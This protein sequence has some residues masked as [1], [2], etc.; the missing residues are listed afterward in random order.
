MFGD[1]GGGKA[2]SG[3]LE[4][5]EF[6]SLEI[7]SVAE[8][9]DDSVEVSL[10]GAY[11]VFALKGNAAS[12]FAF[13]LERGLGVLEESEDFVD[14]GALTAEVQ[15]VLAA[16]FSPGEPVVGAE[17]SPAVGAPGGGD[18]ALGGK[19]EWIFAEEG[20]GWVGVLGNG[21]VHGI[22]IQSGGSRGCERGSGV[23]RVR[24]S[25]FG[26]QGSGRSSEKLG[27]GQEGDSLATK[28]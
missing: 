28:K 15:G 17:A 21:H 10:D 24:A 4:A 2:W 11:E 7:E 18:A 3:G 5:A 23:V 19:A 9:A 8:K 6:P 22:A 14:E 1:V 26:L 25:G 12:G 20:E 27:V 16:V 13:Q